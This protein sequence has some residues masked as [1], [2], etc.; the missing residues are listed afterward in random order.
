MISRGALKGKNIFFKHGG[1]AIDLASAQGAGPSRVSCKPLPSS[2]KQGQ[3]FGS[4]F[5]HE[6]QL[7][8][9]KK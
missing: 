6:T 9:K 5:S 3:H 7:K 1:G 8:N 4:S 2:V